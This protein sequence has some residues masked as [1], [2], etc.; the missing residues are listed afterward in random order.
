MKVYE[1]TE[2]EFEQQRVPILGELGTIIIVRCLNG[3]RMVWELGKD[4]LR[5]RK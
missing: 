3:E 1:V 2:E 4:G 5:I